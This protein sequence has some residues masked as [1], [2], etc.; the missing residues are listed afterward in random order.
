MSFHIFI[1]PVNINSVGILSDFT[2]T[3]MAGTDVT[4]CFTYM[5]KV[6]PFSKCLLL[7]VSVMTSQRSRQTDMLS[8]ACTMILK[9]NA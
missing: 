4:L 6:S 5:G 2:T 8:C 1:L 9:L 3:M 7:R